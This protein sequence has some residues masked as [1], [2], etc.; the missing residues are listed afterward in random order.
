MVSRLCFPFLFCA[1]AAAL[2]Q[3]PVTLE[4][5]VD[6]SGGGEAVITNLKAVP[7]TAYLIQVFLEPCNPSPRPAVF[8]AADAALTPGGEPLVRFQFRSEP[9][10]A[11]HCNKV[12]VS[13]PARAE[14]KAAIY[15][16]GTSFGQPK[17]V[18]S[19]LDSRRFQLEQFETV[20]TRLKVRNAGSVQGQVLVADLETS[21]AALEAEKTFPFPCL[22]DVPELA[23]KELKE[24]EASQPDQIARTIKLFESLRNKLLDARP[25]LR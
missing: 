1:G 8:R 12:G 13:V 25:S 5:R 11:A 16:D 3:A 19:L 14:L 6:S 9:L 21:L 17:W 18:N 2:A 23:L 4:S 20:L 24:T 10:G 7:L 15:Q 22:L